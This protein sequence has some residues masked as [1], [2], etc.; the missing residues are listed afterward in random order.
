[1]YSIAC[2]TS[3]TS[4]SGQLFVRYREEHVNVIAQVLTV[5]VDHE[6]TSC[7]SCILSANRVRVD[8]LVLGYVCGIINDGPDEQT[9]TQVVLGIRADFQLSTTV[10][11]GSLRRLS[12]HLE[13][14]EALF[15]GG[16]S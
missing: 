11:E 1:M 9:T 7:R 10:S 12:T 16:Q 15:Q 8:L 3:Q 4:A 14:V 2:G 13:V 6:H 5:R